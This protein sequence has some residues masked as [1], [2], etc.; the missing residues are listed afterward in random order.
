MAEKPSFVVDASVVAR[1]Y[2]LNPPYLR[3]A[4]QI[5]DDFR[6]ERI[7]I[8]A[9]NNLLV[10]VSGSIHH[11][12]ITKLISPNLVESVLQD[13][14]DLDIPTIEATDLIL[15]AFRLSRRLGC[16]Y[17]DS[18]YLAAAD[19]TG[20]PFIHADGRLHE[21]LGGRFNAEIWIEDY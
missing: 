11:G 4:L 14:L 19:L 2:L 3:Q 20:Y 12:M 7:S 21:S 15:P 18:L 6:E 10:E 5:R 17:Y 13:L 9:P 16:S 8:F 1:W